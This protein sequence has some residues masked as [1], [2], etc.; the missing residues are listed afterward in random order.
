MIGKLTRV[1]LREVWPHEA[2][3]FTTWLTENADVLSEAIGIQLNNVE[4]EQAA[5]SF[6]VDI[7]AEDQDE[8]VVVV[9]NQLGKSDHDHLGKL[10]TYLASFDAKI[11]VWIVSDARPEHTEAINWLNKAG[12]S[13]F[14]L[15]KVECV[16]IGSSE[17][18]PL[19]TLITKP[20]KEFLEIGASKKEMSERHALR[21]QFW[22]QLLDKHKGRLTLFSRIS[23]G[24]KSWIGTSSGFSGVD[25]N[26]VIWQESAAVEIYIDKGDEKE[27]QRIFDALFA[28]SAE[29]ERE[30]GSSL[31]WQSLEGRRA[32]RIRMPEVTIGGLKTPEKWPEIQE[33]LMQ[34]MQRTDK[35]FKPHIQALKS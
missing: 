20:T 12:V 1:P 30:F 6:S 16:K 29:I 3:D 26:Y 17:P 2:Y 33:R 34:D 28:H 35:V 4:R 19:L 11:A 7:I 5:G 18:A 9:E 21:Y 25:Y 22:A 8:N 23:P 27:N 10:I 31:D 15:V 32:C 13:A 24:K 14:Y